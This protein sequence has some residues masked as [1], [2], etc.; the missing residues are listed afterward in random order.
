MRNTQKYFASL[1]AGSLIALTTIIGITPA[2]AQIDVRNL[3]TCLKEEGSSLDVLVLM[4][5]SRSLRNAT[6]E[7]AT[8]RKIDQGSDPDGKR[9]KIL[10]SSLKILRT[11]AEESGRNFNVSLRN[12]GDNSDPKELAALKER[13]VEWTGKTSDQ[14]LAKFV[15]NALYDD[16]PGTQW[17]NGLVSAKDQFKKRIGEATLAGTRSCSIMFWITDGAPTDS[18]NPICAPEGNA[19]INW[20]RENNILVL[21]GL[22][23]P[24]EPSE[25][26]KA[27]QF[28]PLVRG[29]TCGRNEQGWTKGE[30]IEAKDI[31]DLAWGFVG[32]IASIKNL[33]NLNGNGSSFNVDPSTS[34]IEIYT[35]K[36]ANNWEIRKPDG[37]L[38]CSAAD[39]NQGSRC[40]VQNDSDIGI[41]TVTIFPD[42]PIDAAGAWTISPGVNTEDFLVYGGLSTSNEKSRNTKPNL[43]ISQFSPEAEEG[44]KATFLAS[45]INP[46]G[47]AFSLSGFKSVKIC[48]QVKSSQVDACETGKSSVNLSV[49]PSTT[50]K[51]VSFEAVLVSENDPSREY[52]ISATAKINVIPSG[53]FPSL[54]CEKEPCIL[55][56]LAN[57]NSKAISVLL[58]KAAKSGAQEG[59]VVL[60]EAI[61]L[62][63]K[64]EGRGDER[65][66]FVIQKENGDVVQWNNQSQPLRPGEKLTLTVTTDL[67]GSSAIQG[68]LKYQ[69]S[70]NGQDIIRQLDFKFNVGSAKNWPILIGLMLL[71]YLITIGLPYAFLLWSARRRSVL[72]VSDNQFSYL[73]ESIVI[74]EGGK[75][76]TKASLVE[77][78]LL[79]KFPEP[80]HEG[81]KYMEVSEGARS[82]TIGSVRFE[83]I[84]PKWNPF[85]EPVTHV[86]IG[87]NHLLSTFGSSE[88]LSERVFFSR[89]LTN[90]AVVYFPS[91]VNL[92]PVNQETLITEAPSSTSDLFAPSSKETIE[93]NLVVKKGDIFA[94]VLY[95][96]PRYGDRGKSLNELNSKLKDSVDSANLSEHIPGLRQNELELERQRV[97]EL[98]KLNDAKIN[99]KSNKAKIITEGTSDPVSQENSES[100]AFSYFENQIE[101]NQK[102]FF[103]DDVEDPDSNSGTK[104]WD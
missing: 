2:R 7:E 13:W 8:A 74:P 63:D 14:D 97:E 104:K 84:P 67:G 76:I 48:A 77:N 45:L 85:V 29:E 101:S 9:G 81:L 73:E 4:D 59:S 100:G 69:V 91:E 24:L 55:S 52:R 57:K 30:V 46:D 23:K 58:V 103:T 68:I 66:K 1:I 6:V 17:T 71:A 70:A 78:S 83:A 95:I 41:V 21:G 33:I 31:S 32:L 60:L 79:S 27:S 65:F 34:H 19:S 88:F 38:F 72:T 22:L 61:I 40:S 44:K 92:A 50:D 80:S 87:G 86:Y 42:K 96:V 64:I 11:L 26:A 43:V 25:A 10:T 51:S 53:F 54:V 102:N 49:I 36:A 3:Q 90:E 75:G 28:G 5:S 82:V 62:S 99:K 56:N 93:S 12:F 39:A 20:F 15:E 35:R 94:T 98:K 16:S 18:T 47:S 89:S 37:S